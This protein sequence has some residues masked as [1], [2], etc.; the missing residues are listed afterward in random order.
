MEHSFLLDNK[1]NMINN[2]IRLLLFQLA[3]LSSTALAGGSIPAAIV[4][5][6]EAVN[7]EIAPFIWVSGTVIGR[8]DS[9]IAAEVEG[10]LETV[11]EVGDRIN[12]NDV[13]AK[14]DDTT[15]RLA[16]NQ[17]ESEVKPIATMVEFY[18]REAERLEKLAKQNNAARNQ[19]DQTQTNRDEALAKIRVV[20][21]KLAMA[22]DNFN[23]TTVRAPFSGVVTERFK[24]P[25]E[26]VDAGDQIVRL[27]N[28]DRVE[29]Q[30]RIKQESFG[31]IKPGD[32]IKIRGPSGDVRGIIRVAIPVGDDISRLYEIRVDFDN[33]D[34][35][36]GTA[37][38]IASP[39]NEKQNVIAVSRDALVIRQSGVIIYK[40]NGNN[41]AELVPV[42]TGMSNTTHIQVFGNINEHDKIVVRG[43]ERLRPG[44]MV[45][46][47]SGSGG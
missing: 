19:L 20:K 17:I 33:P 15:Y 14:V 35:S 6:E 3:I 16:L 29:I 1:N 32:A 13:I 5:V 11:L 46:I 28:T 7:I 10:T 41:Q 37:V 43:N 22:R 9:K 8:F 2:I 4:Q 34:W 47:I 40:I 18:R 24:A 30:A 25:G 42:E 45:E 31:Y 38:Q 26:R 39:I 27:I 44:Q 36:A 12:Q 21:A 23:R